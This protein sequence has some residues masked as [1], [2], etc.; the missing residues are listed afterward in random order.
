MYVNMHMNNAVQN[1]S[2]SFYVDLSLTDVYS[3]LPSSYAVKQMILILLSWHVRLT[4]DV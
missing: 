2:T 1:M 3:D 4:S